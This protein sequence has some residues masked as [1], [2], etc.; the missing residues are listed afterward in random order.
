M[1]SVR[2]NALDIHY[3]TL[4]DPADPPMLLIMGIGAQLIDWPDEFCQQLA[5]RGFY[6][7]LM[8][9][10]DAGLST[11][12]DDLG[13]PDLPAILGG[14]PSTVA[15][16]FADMAA[17][18]AG[19]LK[20]LGVARAHIVGASMGGMIA[21]QFVI[22]HPDLTASLCSIMSTTGDRSVGRP[23]PEAAAAITRPAARTREEAIAAGAAAS[24]MIGSPAYPA[25]E[26][27][28][29][30]RAAAKYDRSFRPAGSARQLSA[31]LASADRTAP[32]HEVTAPTV[33]IHGEADPLVDVS[34][35]RATAGAVPGASLVTFPGM[36]H[37]L[38]RALWPQ[39]IGA[40][41]GNAARA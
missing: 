38:P 35:G 14:D 11:S 37:D 1:P 5:D 19:L 15:Y 28:L 8:D 26:P 41:V 34:G 33:V 18:A 20:A 3:E 9:N 31:L 40:I 29:R 36:G 24:R 4:G 25:S 16:S 22:D 30:R 32:L 10:R 2:V 6:L 7:I 23:T 13:V 27:E 39:L 12:L 17:D 21:Q